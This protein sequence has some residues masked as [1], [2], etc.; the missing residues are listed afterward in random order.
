MVLKMVYGIIEAC[1]IKVEEERQEK[2]RTV[3]KKISS[4]ILDRISRNQADVSIIK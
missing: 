3:I 2:S 4:I 1:S